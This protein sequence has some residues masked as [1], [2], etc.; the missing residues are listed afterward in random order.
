MGLLENAESVDCSFGKLPKGS[1]LSYQYPLPSSKDYQAHDDAPPRPLLP[2]SYHS[3]EPVLGFSSFSLSIREQEHV[4]V[5]QTTWERAQ[6]LESS[7]RPPDGHKELAAEVQKQRLTSRFWEICTL[8]P[9]KSNADHLVFKIQKGG[10]KS[11]NSLTDEK[12]KSEALREYCRNMFVNWSPCGIVIHPDAP[13]LGALPHGLVYDPKEDPRYGLVHVKCRQL[14]SFMGC[15]FLAFK[16]G[17]LQL[18][19]T[20][21]LYWHVQGE[22]MI[23]GMS[24]C[25]LLVFSKED[26]LVQ[27]IYRDENIISSMK[28]KLDNFFFCHYLPRLHK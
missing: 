16:Y 25:D 22:M 12:I 3:L 20:N 2:L 7:T 24:W 19:K 13:W 18:K 14:R 1:P 6:C 8:R 10:R 15:G 9:G 26:I 21:S 5:M 23:T 27:R 11:K 17:V 28:R 4:S